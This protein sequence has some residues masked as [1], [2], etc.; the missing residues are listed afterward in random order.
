[1]VHYRDSIIIGGIRRHVY[2]PVPGE[3]FVNAGAC[4][5]NWCSCGDTAC[6]GLLLWLIECLMPGR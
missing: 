1:M 6:L 3:G 5:G 2:Y 4:K